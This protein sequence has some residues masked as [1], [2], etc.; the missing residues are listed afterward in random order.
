MISAAKREIES[1]FSIF[2]RA[3]KETKDAADKSFVVSQSLSNRLFGK[4]QFKSKFNSINY[5]F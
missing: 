5:K 2:Q 1:N 3:L 4:E